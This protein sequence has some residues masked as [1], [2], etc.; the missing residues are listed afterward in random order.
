[1]VCWASSTRL[2]TTGI[3]RAGLRR[4]AGGDQFVE[5][6]GVMLLEGVHPL[7]QAIERQTVRRQ[8]E[9]VGGQF[10]IA[11]QRERKLPSGSL[12]GARPAR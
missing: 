1:M 5:A 8:D 7:A 2:N 11:R 3:F 9:R 4:A 12:S 6:R 10:R